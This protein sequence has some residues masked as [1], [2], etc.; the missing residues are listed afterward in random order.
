MDIP[1]RSILHKQRLQPRSTPCVYTELHLARS[2]VCHP[3]ISMI[4][5]QNNHSSCKRNS[6][7]QA[8]LQDSQVFL[9]LCLLCFV[10]SLTSVATYVGV[11]PHKSHFGSWLKSIRRWHL[12]LR[13]CVDYISSPSSR[14]NVADARAFQFSQAHGT[15][16]SRSIPGSQL[17]TGELYVF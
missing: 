9:L 17:R 6:H 5:I 11:S 4:S 1:R 13:K 8:K 2:I 14:Q 10:V 15:G 16:G 7:T 3:K 12:Y